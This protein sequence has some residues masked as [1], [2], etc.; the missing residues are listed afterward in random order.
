MSCSFLS[1]WTVDFG[2]INHPCFEKDKFEN[3]HKYKKYAIVLGDNSILEVQGIGS[4]LIHMKVLDNVL[5]VFNLRIN[6]LSMIQV[7]KKG[8]SF[9]FDSQSWCI[10]KGLATIVKGSVKDDL[11]IMDQVLSKMCLATSVCSRGNL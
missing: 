10:K 11:Y 4:V 1:N 3:F 7:A 8:Y 5:Y 2:C 6:L 9:N